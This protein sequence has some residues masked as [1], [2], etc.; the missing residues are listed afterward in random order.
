ME[1]TL[2]S[3]SLIV[4]ALTSIIVVGSIVFEVLPAQMKVMEPGIMVRVEDTEFSLNR[5]WFILS[6]TS[7][8]EMQNITIM[9]TDG[10]VCNMS[11][12]SYTER[13]V[14]VFGFCEGDL[15]GDVVVIAVKVGEYTYQYNARL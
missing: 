5:T 6:I 3:I 7:D 8:N 10:T 14:K 13:T 4:I 12:I 1:I 9:K 15:R 2:E 11:K